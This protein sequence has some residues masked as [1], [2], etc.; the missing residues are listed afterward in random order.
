VS[1]SYLVGSWLNADE[2]DYTGY[3]GEM[4][5]GHRNGASREIPH[6][7]KSGQANVAKYG[8]NI[9]SPKTTKV[10]LKNRILPQAARLDKLQ[11][12][13]VELEE[14][15]R[16]G[17]FS[18]KDYTLLRDVAFAK[19]ARAETL[20]KKA[21]SVKAPSYDDELSFNMPQDE[22]F[23]PYETCD[24]EY[25]HTEVATPCGVSWIDKLP[26]TNSFKKI[27]Q[28][29]CKVS[30]KL[31]YFSQRAKAYYQTLKEV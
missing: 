27:L 24:V 25:T 17:E 11:A 22:D 4:L 1:R 2:Y 16:S 28:I 8:D 10:P 19:K 26:R 15:Y 14:A 13:I 6:F 3:S 21:I 12:E 5:M 9:L 31:V 20:Y 7:T 18:L 23:S 30:V 29:A